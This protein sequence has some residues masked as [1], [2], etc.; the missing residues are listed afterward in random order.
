MRKT[1]I[2][3]AQATRPF[4]TPT[5]AMGPLPGGWIAPQLVLGP[6]SVGLWAERDGEAGRCD[7]AWAGVG[8]GVIV[9]LAVGL[10]MEDD[11]E[12]FGA[13][14]GPEP[15]RQAFKAIRRSGRKTRA[16]RRCTGED[17]RGRLQDRDS[18]PDVSFLVG[19]G[20]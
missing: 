17:P 18:F 9:G 10:A 20:A 7:L 14:P 13:A 19:S 1:V 15:S 2:A 6:A 5:A 11:G 12:D 3:V 16:R 4:S 8:V